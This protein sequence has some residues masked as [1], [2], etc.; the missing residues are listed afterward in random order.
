MHESDSFLL[1]SGER[2]PGEDLCGFFLCGFRLPAHPTLIV[3]SLQGL[4]NLCKTSLDPPHAGAPRP[5]Q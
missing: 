3:P 4:T 2:S 5:H 1:Y